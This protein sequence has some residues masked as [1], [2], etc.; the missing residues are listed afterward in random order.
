M[1]VM[2]VAGAVGAVTVIYEAEVAHVVFADPDSYVWIASDSTIFRPGGIF[3]S[4]PGA[5]AVLAMTILVG[6]PLLADARGR[7][8]FGLAACMGVSL[9]ALVLTFTRAGVIALACGIVVYLLLTERRLVTLPRVTMAGIGITVFMLMVFPSLETNST[10]QQGVVRPGN[11]SERES[12]WRLAM[13]IATANVQTMTLGI[14]SGS[15]AIGRA[16]NG[17][18]PAE[19]AT[20]PVLVE[21]GT[22][23]QYVMA[24]LENGVIGLAALVAWLAAALAAAVKLARRRAGAIAAAL[25]GALTAFAVIM[26][27]NNALLDP[28]SFAM[29]ALSSGLIVA[30]VAG[31]RQAATQRV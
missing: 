19:L 21:H 4:P 22:H 6:L 26:V 29:A 12:F 7:Q 15:A 30:L 24:L 31:E 28:P 5:A 13:P 1:T 9:L 8:K 11:L 17:S 2:V 23:S 18:I 27:V 16:K 3:G 25:A 14:G 10:Y 20:S